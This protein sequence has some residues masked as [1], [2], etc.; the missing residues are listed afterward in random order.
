VPDTV[1][2]IGLFSKLFAEQDVTTVQ[3]AENERRLRRYARS[4]SPK[5]RSQF[6]G[7][8]GLAEQLLQRQL[9]HPLMPTSAW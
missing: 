3:D 1:I 5:P 9:T 8:S 7:I 6:A 4:G 2:V